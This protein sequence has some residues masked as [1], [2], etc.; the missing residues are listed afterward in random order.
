MDV[1]ERAHYRHHCRGDSK[2]K[3]K[4][5]IIMKL[6][7]II[8]IFAVAVR[9]YVRFLLESARESERENKSNIISYGLRFGIE[10]AEMTSPLETLSDVVA[11]SYFHGIC[12]EMFVCRLAVTTLY[13]VCLI[14]VYKRS[15]E[16]T[17][18]NNYV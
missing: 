5:R 10:I 6:L 1:S 16:I 17:T 12:R 14:Y 11:L 18:K 15:T 4:R 9:P 13:R 3:I 2:R 7:A 8:L